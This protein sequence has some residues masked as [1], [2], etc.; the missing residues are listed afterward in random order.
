MLRRNF[1]SF[2]GCS[3]LSFLTKNKDI[4]VG[5]GVINIPKG[6]IY[7]VDDTHRYE[8]LGWKDKKH[9]TYRRDGVFHR[10]DGPAY[11]SISY[12]TQSDKICHEWKWFNDGVIQKTIRISNPDFS[13][14]QLGDVCAYSEETLLCA[15]AIQLINKNCGQIYDYDRFLWTKVPNVDI[16]WFEEQIGMTLEQLYS[17]N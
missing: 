10:E 2:L 5:N 16:S 1:L 13:G 3:P 14:I 7:R 4:H 12:D 8:S 11:I 17:F 6:C 15:K 9:V